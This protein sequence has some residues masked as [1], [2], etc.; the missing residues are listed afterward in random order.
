[1]AQGWISGRRWQDE[2]WTPKKPAAPKQKYIGD[3]DLAEP[4]PIEEAQKRLGQ[5]LGGIKEMP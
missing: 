5:I 1:M 2:V 3:M 4:V